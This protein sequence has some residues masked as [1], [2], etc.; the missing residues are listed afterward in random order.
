MFGNGIDTNAE[1]EDPT[2][3]QR[4]LATFDWL[5]ATAESPARSRRIIAEAADAAS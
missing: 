5:R 2:E 4:A 1:V 3:K